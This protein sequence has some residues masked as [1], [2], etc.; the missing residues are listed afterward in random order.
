MR[1]TTPTLVG[2][3]LTRTF[4]EGSSV[5]TAVANVSLHFYGGELVLLMGPSGSGKSTLLALLLGL[6]RPNQGKVWALKEDLWAMN[7]TEREAFRRK[8]FGFIFQGYNLFPS[9]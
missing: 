2:S 8:H 1:S 9:L 7:E 4:G 3:H 6:M 5:T